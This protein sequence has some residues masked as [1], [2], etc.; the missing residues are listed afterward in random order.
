MKANTAT[1]LGRSM[2]LDEN[3]LR[4]ASS[5]LGFDPELTVERMLA[6]NQRGCDGGE[7]SIGFARGS[8]ILRKLSGVPTLLLLGMTCEELAERIKLRGLWLAVEA[9]KGGRA[10]EDPFLDDPCAGDPYDEP[11]PTARRASRAEGREI[12]G[13]MVDGRMFVSED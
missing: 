10:H 9:E 12:A 7:C 1:E 6:T 8:D 4:W 11:L 5:G 13:R 2:N 3:E